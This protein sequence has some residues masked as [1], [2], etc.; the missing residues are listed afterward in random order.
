MILNVEPGGWGARV[1]RCRRAPSTSPLRGRTT[2]MPPKRPASASTAARWI[3]GVDRRAHVRAGA[4]ACVA[5]E[6]AR[7]GAQLAAGRAGEPAR[8]TR[9]RGRVRPT[10]VRRARRARAAPR[11]ARAA[12]G[13]RGRRSRPPAR[14]RS[15]SRASPLAIARAVA[16][17]DRR[18]RGHPR[19]CASSRSPARSPGNAR[20]GC[21]A[22]RG[23]AVVALADRERDGRAQSAEDARARVDRHG[24]RRRPRPR[25][26]APARTLGERRA[27]R[28]ARGRRGRSAAAAAV[29]RVGVS[30]A[31]IAA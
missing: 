3:V 28:R 16:G 9:A 14:P 26:A 21:Q 29:A 31:C 25:A 18:A 1:A 10:G 30:I 17:L 5:R 27:S 7:A 2:A 22:T 12:P 4:A 8:R 13:R 19:R 15:D 24:D 20:C 11:R 6:H 23:L